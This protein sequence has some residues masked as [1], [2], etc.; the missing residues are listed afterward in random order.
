MAPPK[1]GHLLGDGAIWSR[2]ENTPGGLTAFPGIEG[3]DQVKP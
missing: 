1:A 2:D 3:I